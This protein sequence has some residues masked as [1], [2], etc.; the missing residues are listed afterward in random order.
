MTVIENVTHI[1]QVLV[2]LYMSQPLMGTPTVL[3]TQ[4]STV[5]F[6]WK[7]FAKSSLKVLLKVLARFIILLILQLDGINFQGSFN[8]WYTCM[9]TTS[10][11][12]AAGG[13]EI[14]K[15]MESECL[16]YGYHVCGDVDVWEAAIGEEVDCHCEPNSET[17][18]YVVTVVKIGTV[19]GHSLKKLS[20]C[21]RHFYWEVVWLDGAWQGKGGTLMTYHRVGWDPMYFKVGRKVQASTQTKETVKIEIVCHNIHYYTLYCHMNLCTQSCQC[22]MN[23]TFNLLSKNHY[24]LTSTFNLASKHHYL[25]TSL[26]QPLSY[27]HKLCCCSLL[28]VTGNHWLLVRFLLGESH[29]L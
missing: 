20:V 25:L 15:R 10:A 3:Q 7:I 2:N 8:P 22:T 12:A 13:K 29:S 28:R 26:S 21:T 6:G 18:H 24:L 9:V 17:D 1:V 19:V 4:G 5:F 14:E 23:Y 11:T 16:I 27:G